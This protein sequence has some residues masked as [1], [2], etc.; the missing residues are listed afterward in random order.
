LRHSTPRVESND[1]VCTRCDRDC[2]GD[3]DY[4]EFCGVMTELYQV[5][6]VFGTVE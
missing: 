6:Q 2:S 5:L 3:L 1:Q 4:D